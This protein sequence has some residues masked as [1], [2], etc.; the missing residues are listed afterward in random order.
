MRSSGLIAGGEILTRVAVLRAASG[1]GAECV[2]LLKARGD[3]VIGV[4]QE[5]V[6]WADRWI[7]LSF[8]EPDTTE[9]IAARTDGGFDAIICNAVPP[10]GDDDPS[11]VLKF[12]LLGLLAATRALMP[13][14]NDGGS[15]TMIA[16]RASGRS[17][18]TLEEIRAVLAVKTAHL[19]D[20]FVVGR[21]IDQLQAN[22]L[23][24]EAIDYWS[25][26]QVAGLI[27]RNQRVN[28]VTPA[29]IVSE[30]LDGFL[31]GFGERTKN[32]IART[33]RMGRPEEVAAV[34]AFLCSSDSSWVNGQNIVVDGGLSAMQ[35][36]ETKLA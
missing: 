13:K 4:D 26:L 34:V 21:G 33:G 8:G 28:V 24:S 2:T 31:S 27:A 5:E 23:S 7:Q 30:L 15:I 12:C 18:A 11:G 10:G 22:D 6:D 29:P 35:E 9:Q 16:T 25:K 19:M 36:I 32:V 14:L 17:R 1:I 20:A 3:T